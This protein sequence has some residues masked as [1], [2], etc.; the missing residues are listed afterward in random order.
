MFE[1]ILCKK[2]FFLA[3]RWLDSF[4]A[5]WP[6]YLAEFGAFINKLEINF[7]IS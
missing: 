5:E 7:Y 1:K 3:N 2:I 4:L 6:F